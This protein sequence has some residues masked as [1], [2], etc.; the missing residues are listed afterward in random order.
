MTNSV[1]RILNITFT[2]VLAAHPIVPLVMGIRAPIR[3]VIQLSRVELM[4][5]NPQS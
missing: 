3:G 1:V 4:K 2:M 5:R